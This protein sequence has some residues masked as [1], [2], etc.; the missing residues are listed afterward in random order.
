M[1]TTETETPTFE[2]L[3]AAESANVIADFFSDRSV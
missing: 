1:T 2:F 3:R